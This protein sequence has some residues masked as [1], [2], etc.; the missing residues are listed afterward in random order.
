MDSTKPPVPADA[1]RSPDGT[2]WWDGSTWQ[3]FAS[4][5]PADALR[6]PDGQFWWDGTKWVAVSPPSQAPAAASPQEPAPPVYTYAAPIPSQVSINSIGSRLHADGSRFVV[7]RGSGAVAAVIAYSDVQA[8]YIDQRVLGDTVTIQTGSETRS[9]Q[10]CTP[11]EV[12]TQLVALLRSHGVSVEERKWAAA[13][14][15]TSGTAAI[16][17]MRD[18]GPL[19]AEK[20]ASVGTLIVAAGMIIVSAFLVWYTFQT[21]GGFPVQGSSGL[22]NG[23]GIWALILGGYTIVNAAVVAVATSSRAIKVAVQALWT[24]F[25]LVAIA[26]VLGIVALSSGGWVVVGTSIPLD[27]S[28]GPGLYLL[29]VAA[30]ALLIAVIRLTVFLRRNSWS[31][32]PPIRVM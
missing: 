19:S 7:T 8:V 3:P 2:Q 10:E 21:Q 1:L 22:T 17:L 14:S 12:V 32:S 26:L 30:L 25:V 16:A 13:G 5:A 9:F 28:P 27:A 20:V 24:D 15:A 29:G 4:E 6:S 23:Y 18:A 11:R 31:W